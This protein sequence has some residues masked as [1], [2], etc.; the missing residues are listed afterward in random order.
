[1]RKLLLAA[2][3]LAAVAGLTAAKF[4]TSASTATRQ[5]CMQL[6]GGLS[7]D[8]GFFRFNSG[9]PTD[10]GKIVRLSG[11]VAGL[12]PVYGTA[13]VAKDG[14]YLEI[15]ATFFADADE[16]QIDVTFFPPNSSTGS[17]YADYGAYGTGQSVDAHIVSCTLEP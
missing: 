3:L 15:G 13:L 1:M 9:R 6:S 7:G 16:G 12:S 10:S 17:G 4:A 5:F 11:R 2:V 14:S 8:L